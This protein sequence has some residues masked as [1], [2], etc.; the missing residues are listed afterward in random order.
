MKTL[1]S[2]LTTALLAAFFAAPAAH[3]QQAQPRGAV[4][5]GI[6]L[7]TCLAG[8]GGV[9]C[10]PEFLKC[11]ASGQGATADAAPAP[12]SANRRSA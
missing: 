1:K 11:M 8:G 4:D 5:C 10:L 3:A 2:I 6:K 9:A 7:A 12:A